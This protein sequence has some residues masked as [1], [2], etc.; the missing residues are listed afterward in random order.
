RPLFR[1][2]TAASIAS[3][4]I[5]SCCVNGFVNFVAGMGG[6]RLLKPYCY[7]EYLALQ[8][9]QFCTDQ[10]PEFTHKYPANFAD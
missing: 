1:T 7:I 10:R 6:F 8:S 5:A 4:A 3:W 2:L 9:D